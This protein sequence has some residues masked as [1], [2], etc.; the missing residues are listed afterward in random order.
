M[1]F[2]DSSSVL[3][4]MPSIGPFAP[5]NGSVLNPISTASGAFGGEVLGLEFNV[6]F[7][8]AGV[9]HG[10]SGL[11][12]G[13]LNVCGLAGAQAVLN[14]HSVRQALA[15]VNTLL[16]GGTSVLAISDLGT[17]VQDLNASFADGSPS[18]FA[19]AH[20]VNGNCP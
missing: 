12:L 1:T 13:D 5:L 4:Y 15:V 14:N 8:D 7:T 18:T 19:Q 10:S 11:K 6:D 17:L 3:R 2:S 20:I 9:L 16:G